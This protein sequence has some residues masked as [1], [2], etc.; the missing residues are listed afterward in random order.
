M[1][2]L[3]TIKNAWGWVGLAPAAVL[4]VNAFG[5]ILVTALDGQVWR[6]C[7]EELSAD[8]VGASLAE[9]GKVRRQ[10]EFVEDWNMTAMVDEARRTLGQLGEGWC[11]CLKIPGVLGGEY[12]GDNLATI[13]LQELVGAS[14]DLA[15][16]VSELPD[17][18]Q[19]RLIVGQPH[20]Q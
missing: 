1:D 16:Q 4:E 3:G 12:G 9:F 18:A 11:Y 17:G 13:S 19:V 7:P 8:V 5:N 10:P 15:K 20:K 2:L 14:G 6:I